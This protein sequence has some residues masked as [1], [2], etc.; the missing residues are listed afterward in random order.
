[1]R[2]GVGI[3]GGREDW[4]AA[5]TFLGEAERLGVDRDAHAGRHRDDGAHAGLAL[6]RALHPRPGHERAAGDRGLARHPLVNEVN[7]ETASAVKSAE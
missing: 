3:G 4:E 2:V 1:M 7:A 6:R 5:A